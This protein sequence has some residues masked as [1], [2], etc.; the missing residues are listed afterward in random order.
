MR[1]SLPADFFFFIDEMW[2]S[3]GGRGLKKGK[4]LGSLPEAAA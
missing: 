2:L 4:G 3:G 1:K